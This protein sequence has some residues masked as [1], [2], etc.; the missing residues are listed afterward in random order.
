MENFA[1]PSS[2]GSIKV[3]SRAFVFWSS[4]VLSLIGDD[5]AGTGIGSR[6]SVACAEFYVSRCG[7]RFQSAGDYSDRYRIRIVDEEVGLSL[8]E[9][10][11]RTLRS[12][13]GL[14]GKREQLQR[15]YRDSYPCR[16]PFAHLFVGRPAVR[17]DSRSLL[18][19]G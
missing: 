13:R 3:S 16:M 11:P 5:S 12:W 17:A 18:Y 2:I 8:P 9:Q 7:S 14:Q 1:K 4:G 19:P 15:A 6:V 10:Q